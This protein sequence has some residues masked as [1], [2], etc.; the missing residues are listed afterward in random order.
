MD[1][2]LIALIAA[3]VI[4]MSVFL[5]GYDLDQKREMKVVALTNFQINSDNI[6]KLKYNI[7]SI[8]VTDGV[9]TI[10]GWAIVK[11][12]DINKVKFQVILKNKDGKMYKTNTEIIQ[13]DD[14][15]ALEN[16][17]RNYKNSGFKSTF[18]LSGLEGSKNYK[19]GI[20]MQIGSVVYF[21]WTNRELNL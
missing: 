20:Q 5:V 8:N 18:Y 2:R 14:I 15:T 9:G 10:S 7:D 19:I 1:K 3:I 12:V 13:R 6:N 4:F 16:D 21:S 11:G 17:K